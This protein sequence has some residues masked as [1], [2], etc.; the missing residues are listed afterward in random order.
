MKV[1]SRVIICRLWSRFGCF[2][3]IFL[4]IKSGGRSSFR[5]CRDIVSE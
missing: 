2:L 3:F 4:Y 1:F 5:R